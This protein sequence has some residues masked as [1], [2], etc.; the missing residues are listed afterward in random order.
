[1]KKILDKTKSILVK[2]GRFLFVKKEKEHSARYNKI[3]DT[4]NKYSLV[5][6]AL[7]ALTIVFLVMLHPCFRRIASK[8][9]PCFSESTMLFIHEIIFK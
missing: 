3:I 5:G 9:Q 6:H 4:M 8:C 2:A 1:M 7:I